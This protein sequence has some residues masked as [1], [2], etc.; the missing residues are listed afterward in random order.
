LIINKLFDVELSSAN[1][2]AP[3]V[4]NGSFSIEKETFS[5]GYSNFTKS[6]IFVGLKLDKIG[7]K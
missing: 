4:Y 1:L 6:I 3:P 2:I 7:D 5:W